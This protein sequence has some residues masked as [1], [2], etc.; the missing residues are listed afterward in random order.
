MS[1]QRPTRDSM[2]LDEATISNMWEIAAS[3]ESPQGYPPSA[4]LP[5]GL[6]PHAPCAMLFSERTFT[7]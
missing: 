5:S 4:V 6:S 1:D 2:S 7:G 3:A